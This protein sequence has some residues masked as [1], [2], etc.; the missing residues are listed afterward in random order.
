MECGLRKMVIT[1]DSIM[2]PALAEDWRAASDLV[3][4]ARRIPPE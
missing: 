2:I 3:K 1:F 4:P